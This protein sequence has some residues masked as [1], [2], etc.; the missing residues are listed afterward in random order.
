MKKNVL[1][2]MVLV[3]AIGMTACSSLTAA[4]KAEQKAKVTQAVTKALNERQYKI[5]IDMMFPRNGQ[6]TNVSSDFSLEVKGDSVYS[7]LPYFGRAYSVPY[8]GGN[9][10]D[11]KAIIMDYESKK[12]QKGT[13][14]INFN[15]KNEEDFLEFRIEVFDN[16]NTSIDL[17]PRQ[18]ES[19]SFSGR[20]DY[21][22]D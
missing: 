9:G 11:F 14:F 12:D 3:A 17:T 16:G 7:Y 10:L 1:K 20:L 4:Q 21:D 15:V 6:A 22:D 19:I 2:M 18:R 5:D 8:G 13:T